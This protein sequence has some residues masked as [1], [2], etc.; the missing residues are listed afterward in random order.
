L[1]WSPLSCL[2]IITRSELGLLVLGNAWGL[3]CSWKNGSL[4]LEAK[5][6]LVFQEHPGLRALHGVKPAWLRPAK[7]T[8]E[9]QWSCKICSENNLL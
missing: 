3:G 6:P 1:A 9:T 7:S 4:R 8:I 2:E 5:G